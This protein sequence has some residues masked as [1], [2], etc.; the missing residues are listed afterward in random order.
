MPHKLGAIGHVLKANPPPSDWCETTVKTLGSIVGGSTPAS[1]EQSFWRNGT[2]PWATP[3]DITAL[4]SRFISDTSAKITQ[5]GLDS[6]AAQLLPVGSVLFTSRA[7]IGAK[8]INTVPMATN[9]GFASFIPNDGIRTDFLFYYLDLLTPAFV[10]LGAGTTFLEVSKRD[11][12]KVQCAL[13]KPDEQAAI[14][15]ILDASDTAIERARTAVEEARRVK[16][17]LVQTLFIKGLRRH[18]FHKTPLGSLPAD[19][20]VV[21]VGDVLTEAQY[22]LSMPMLAKGDYPIL[23]M[24]AIQGGQV[25]L[26]D[27]KYVNL[28]K[29][30]AEQYLLRRGDVL[31]NRT[32]S[33]EHVGKVGIFRSDRSAVFASYLIRLQTKPETIDSFYL[34]HL[35][36]SYAVQCRIRRYAT[37]G[38]QQVNIN[39]SNLKRVLIPVPAGA[40]GLDEQH[41][42]ARVL[43]QEEAVIAAAEHRVAALQRLKRGLMQDLL[44]GRVR[45]KAASTAAILSPA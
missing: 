13:P 26:S 12:R 38:V 41:D 28:S 16:R 33:F 6:C 43:E 40:K 15:R 10:R 45:V 5:T 8:A 11:M 21:A 14:A 7:T 17:S 29:P 19:W 22:G 44:T 36:S 23:R 37:P 2:I 31:F 18:T 27:L 20:L 30:L 1:E 25:L 32:N 24:A 35:L 34:G 39:A 42:I 3:T 9:Q 4:H